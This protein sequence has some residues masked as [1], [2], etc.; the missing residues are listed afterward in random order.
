M[1][2]STRVLWVIPVVYVLIVTADLLAMTHIS[3]LLTQRGISVFAV[4]ALASTFWV[5]I[6]AASTLAWRF[7]DRYGLGRSFIGGTVLSALAFAGLALSQHYAA[8]MVG[9]AIIGIA[10]GS[11]W[12]AG[13]AWLAE[14]A[15]PQWRGFYVGLVQTAVGAGTVFGPVLLPLV[16]WAGWAPLYVALGV[17]VLAALVSLCLLAG[18]PEGRAAH[19]APHPVADS[20]G[21]ADALELTAQPHQACAGCGKAAIAARSPAAHEGVGGHWR[22]VALPLTAVATISGVLESGSAALLPSISMRSGFGVAMAAWL[23]TVI[24][25]GGALLPTPLGLLADRMGLRRILLFCWVCLIA[26]A[27][28]LTLVGAIGLPRASA[29][30]WPVGFFLSGMGAVVY[31]LVTVELGHRLTGPGLVRALASLVTAYT[32]GT[33]IGP[34]AGGAIFDRGGLLALAAALVAAGCVGLAMTLRSSASAPARPAA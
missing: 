21:R 20:E 24:G 8:W 31:T 11:S 10:V 5:C 29:A 7:I 4:G 2:S 33:A 26:A 18:Q 22:A 15:P 28:A 3:L 30:L 34:I 25:A 1:P 14:S 12:I 13:E 9:V 6:M 32:A 23:A 16:Q 17:D 27:L 19:P